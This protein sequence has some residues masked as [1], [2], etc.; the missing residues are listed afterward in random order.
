MFLLLCFMYEICGYL[1]PDKHTNCEHEEEVK[2]DIISS[3]G[4]IYCKLICNWMVRVV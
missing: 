2:H 1:S 4:V 3:N